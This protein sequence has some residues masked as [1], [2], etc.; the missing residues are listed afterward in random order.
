MH[1]MKSSGIEMILAA[2]FGSLKSILSG[3]AWPQAL[4]AYCMVTAALL[5]DFLSEGLKSY[6]DI[7]GYLDEKEQAPHSKKMVN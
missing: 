3:K 4:R 7:M 6:D 2:A 1:L 5:N